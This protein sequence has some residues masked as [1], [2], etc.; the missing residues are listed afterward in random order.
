MR[1]SGTLKAL[2]FLPLLT[3]PL[4]AQ[5]VGLAPIPV[6]PSMY[7]TP[8][9]Y[10]NNGFGMV[11]GPNYFL[12][13]P[14]KPFQGM[15]GPVVGL[16]QPANG[17]VGMAA[18]PTHLYARGPRDFYMYN[19]DPRSSPYTYGNVTDPGRLGEVYATTPV[20]TLAP[21]YPFS[22]TGSGRVPLMEKKGEKSIEKDAAPI[23]D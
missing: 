8:P 22:G 21:T 13:P 16:G 2:L 23:K 19:T 15:V 17:S 7:N 1:A 20:P 11:Y 3:A 6:V 5:C 18:F 12:Y 14:G 10:C 9:F 4:S